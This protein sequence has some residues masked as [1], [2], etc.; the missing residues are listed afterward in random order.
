MN[1]RAR[2]PEPRYRSILGADIEHSTGHL[3][4]DKG[5]LRQVMYDLF[6]EA[7]DGAGI[8]KEHRDK[9]LDRGDGFFAL[10]H[11]TDEVPKT[12]MLNSVIP[13][14]NRLLTDHGLRHPEHRFKLR[15]AVHAG[16]VHRDDNGWFGEAIDLTHRL[17]N[18]ME[19]KRTLRRTDASL[20]LV[21]S[22][23]IYQGVIRHGYDGIDADTFEARIR[24]RLGGRY[25][26]GWVHIPVLTTSS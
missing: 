24:V 7:L 5:V 15:I 1:L 14:V 20:V 18:A 23:D 26:R 2:Q 19:L 9:P 11:A 8:T 16:E 12:L 21:A 25:H 10:I 22:D 17:L 3:N 6:D 13:T 4:T